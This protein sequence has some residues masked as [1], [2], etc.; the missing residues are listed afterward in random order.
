MCEEISHCHFH[1]EMGRGWQQPEPVCLSLERV[2][3][4][5]LS[6]FLR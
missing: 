6:L 2:R 5:R 1:S 4:V 3:T